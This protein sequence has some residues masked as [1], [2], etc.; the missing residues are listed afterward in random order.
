M[1]IFLDVIQ[2]PNQAKTCAY[3]RV[4]RNAGES[5]NGKADNK[6]QRQDLRSL[7]SREIKFLIKMKKVIINLVFFIIVAFGV[8]I[9]NGQGQAVVMK[10]DS[11]YIEK[12][13]RTLE[14]FGLYKVENGITTLKS[15][16]Y[17][18]SWEFE[19]GVLTVKCK[20][21]K[22]GIPDYYYSDIMVGFTYNR[23]TPGLPARFNPANRLISSITSLIIED[24]ITK[25]GNAAFWGCRN[26]TTVTIPES[27]TS[28]GDG[29]FF[30]CWKLTSVTIPESVTSIGNGAF[31][32]CRELT[33]ITIPKNVTSI[34]VNAF[35]D[36][37]N[38]TSVTIPESVTSLG[39]FAFTA[40]G[41]LTAVT[42]PHNV[43][44]LNG[45][46]RACKKLT[47]VEVKNPIPPRG[48]PFQKVSLKKVKLIVPAGTKTTYA[49]NKVWKKFGIIEENVV[50]E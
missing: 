27:V 49:K 24:G 40:C 10:G 15:V 41:N 30:G 33:S 14:Y 8:N 42:I 46:F 43:T 18:I 36:C 44:H 9:Q 26:L 7:Q 50:K 34:G 5:A 29:A 11:M 22:G 48:D 25:I 20:D 47:V 45:V 35:T 39:D 23:R 3:L 32:R 4:V 6:Y 31:I 16:D 21:G 38:L 17:S 37:E 13:D 12:S 28:I 2:T 1:S 19:D